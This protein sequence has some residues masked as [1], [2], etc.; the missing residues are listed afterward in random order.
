MISSWFHFKDPRIVQHTQI[1]KHNTADKQKQGTRIA[2]SF[3]D[4]QK[5][6]NKIQHA[7]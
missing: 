1:D 6:T 2:S 4:V 5:K 3:Q 7:S